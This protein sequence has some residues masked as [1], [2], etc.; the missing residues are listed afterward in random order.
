VFLTRFLLGEENDEK[1]KKC[2]VGSHIAAYITNRKSEFR[3]D[4]I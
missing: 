2:G 4:E 1:V 3:K